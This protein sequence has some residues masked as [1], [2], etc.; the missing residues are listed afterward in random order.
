MNRFYFGGSDSSGSDLEEDTLPYPKPL[1]RSAFLVPDFDPTSFLSSLHNRHQTLEDL[2]S[3]LR[4][5]SQELN[6]ELL[7]LVNSNYQ[8]FLS[9]GSS[10]QGGEEK[11]EE[12][13]VGLLGFKRDVEGLKE[14]VDDRRKEVDQLVE[15]KRRVRKEIQRGRGLLEVD[16]RLEELEEGLL[17][18]LKGATTRRETDTDD[19]EIS[20]SEEDSGNEAAKNST[21]ISRLQ[22]RVIQFVYTRKLADKIGSDQ[23]FIAK[24]EERLSRVR[25]TLLLDI[26]SAFKQISTNEHAR[27][28]TLKI[29]NI[30]RELGEPDEALRILKD[31]KI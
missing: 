9:L 27:G 28:T 2:R 4:T 12:V 26:G 18:K 31:R 23:P 1:T 20:E 15:E 19:I 10:L 14:K 17:L 24:Q 29:L 7:D 8:D 25:N 21:S 16:Q 22:R 3:E 5:R 13:R 11:V 6:K 30:Y